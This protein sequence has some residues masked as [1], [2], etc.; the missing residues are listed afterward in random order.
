V[1]ALLFIVQFERVARQASSSGL[2]EN[3]VGHSSAVELLRKPGARRRQSQAL[4]WRPSM[5]SSCCCAIAVMRAGAGSV[6]AG[7]YSGRKRASSN[8][9]S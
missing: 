1:L 2:D 5:L 4:T 7:L 3:R 6:C 9:R 8:L